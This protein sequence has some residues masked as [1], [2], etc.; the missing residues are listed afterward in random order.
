VRLRHVSIE[1]QVQMTGDTESDD[2]SGLSISARDDPPSSI[3]AS[4]SLLKDNTRIVLAASRS[5]VKP[6]TNVSRKN[7]PLKSDEPIEI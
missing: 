5:G 3:L 4:N 1:K 2:L 6:K 7:L